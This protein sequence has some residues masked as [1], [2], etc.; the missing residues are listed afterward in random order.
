[1]DPINLVV[2]DTF[3]IRGRGVVVHPAVDVDRAIPARL[4]VDLTY[5]DGTTRQVPGQLMIEF[6][7]LLAG[8]RRSEVLVVLDESVGAIPPGTKLTARIVDRDRP[9][10]AATE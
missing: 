2:K 4:T 3:V 1:V 9:E 6:L 10:N 5:S 7:V 8:G